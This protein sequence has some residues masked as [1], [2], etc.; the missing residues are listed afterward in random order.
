MKKIGLSFLPIGEALPGFNRT[1]G[2]RFRAVMPGSLERDCPFIL[3]A[4]PER[5]VVRSPVQ[6]DPG[7]DVDLDEAPGLTY[8]PVPNTLTRLAFSG[9]RVRIVEA[10]N[11]N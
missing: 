1:R 8:W 4:G 11:L 5:T 7:S 2:V 6:I 3:P 9:F 10:R